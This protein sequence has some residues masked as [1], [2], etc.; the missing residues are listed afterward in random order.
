MKIQTPSQISNLSYDLSSN[1][2]EVKSRS[3]AKLPT[4]V[5]IIMDGNG[6]WAR[7]RGLPRVEG[8]RQGAES[9]KEVIQAAAELGIKYLTLYAFSIENWNR[10]KEEIDTLMNYLVHYLEKGLPE[11]LK[12]NIKLQAIGQIWRLPLNVQV[13]LEK[14]IKTL[15]LNTGLILT[16]ALSYGG[17]AEI[18][19]A[20]R[21]IAK[22]VREGV[23]DPDEITEEIFAKHLWT[24]DMP[25]P[26]LLIRTS[27]ELRLSN[28]LLWQCSYTEFVVTPVMWPEFRKEHFYA[29][30]EEYSR[31]QRRFGRVS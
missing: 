14:A 11:L 9:A 15:S 19:D 8:H 30:L 10:P 25:D 18:V 23:I 6:R 17:R 20:V 16:L 31:R 21:T 26:D 24:K 5:A 27:G 7:Q 22:K 1:V 28:F 3:F 4:H 13:E 12:A 2:S 29:A